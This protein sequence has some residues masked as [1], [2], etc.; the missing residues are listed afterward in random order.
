M[1]SREVCQMILDRLSTLENDL[2]CLAS[3]TGYMSADCDDPDGGNA[4]R[5]FQICAEALADNA[6]EIRDD[7]YRAYYL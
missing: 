6:H 3:S 4:L 5:V 2:L 7:V 1:A